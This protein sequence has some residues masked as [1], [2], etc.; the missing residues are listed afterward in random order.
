MWRNNSGQMGYDFVNDDTDPDDDNGHGTHCAGISAAETNN[1]LG[2]AGVMN[3]FAKIMAVKVLGESGSGSFDD[4]ANGILWAANNGADVINLSLSG[5]GQNAVLKNA[6][7]TASQKSVIVMAAGN[8]NNE[9]TNDDFVIPAGYAPEFI[10]AISVASIDSTTLNKSSFSNFS[11]SYVEMIAPGSE[12]SGANSRGILST[13]FNSRFARLSGTSMAAP[14]V[15][16]GAGLVISFFKSHDIN[17]SPSD[18]EEI[19]AK[20]AIQDQNLSDVAVNGRRIDMARLTDYLYNKY[21][22]LSNGG[23][24]NEL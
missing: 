6:I 24:R 8:S 13:Y 2:I 10:G 18:V 1:G 12:R 3:G 7:Q 20:A 21:L 22:I 9:I 17:Y 5:T 16:G 19:L 23:M 11:S 4:V 15:A 14:I